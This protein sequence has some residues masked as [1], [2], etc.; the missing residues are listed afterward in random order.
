MNILPQPFGRR[1]NADGILHGADRVGIFRADIDEALGGADGDAGNRHAFDQHEGIALH[2]HAVG[3]GAA[4]ALIGVAADIFLV[5]LGI[6]NGFPLDA[7]GETRAAAAAQSGGGD[8]R[9]DLRAL[10]GERFFQ[11]NESAMRNII[12]KRK[13]I[14]DAAAREGEAFLVLEIG[15]LFGEA[16]RQLVLAALME[17]GIEQALHI[18]RFNRAESHAALRRLNFNK[19][20]KPQKPARTIADNFYINFPGSGFGHDGISHLI[21]ANG[22]GGGILRHINPDHE[23]SSLTSASNFCGVMRPIGR[24]STSRAGDVAHSPRQ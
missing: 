15:K 10:H 6:V 21:G 12:V 5:G 17:L 22:A 20:L 2:H 4:V 16:E 8:F 7:R 11:A 1:R 18:A 19:R 23:A 13:R 24:S 3:E 9:D 14:G